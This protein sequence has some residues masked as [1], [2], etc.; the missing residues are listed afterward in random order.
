MVTAVGDQ[1][2]LARSL[3]VHP[4]WFL[5]VSFAGLPAC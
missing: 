1:T 4:M 2:P 3:L 5:L